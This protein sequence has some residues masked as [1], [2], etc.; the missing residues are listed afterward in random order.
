MLLK[1][2]T[3]LLQAVGAGD[4]AVGQAVKLIEAG[5]VGGIV[6]V[7]VNIGLGGQLQGIFHLE[8][9]AA[10]YAQAGEQLIDV[11]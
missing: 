10:G 4:A 7:D 3:Q 6:D 9:M 1:G 8:A 11:G 5:G 2:A